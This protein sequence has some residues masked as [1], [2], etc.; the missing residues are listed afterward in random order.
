MVT[1][2]APAP[3]TSAPATPIYQPHGISD[4]QRLFHERFPAL[5]TAHEEEYSANFGRFR[6]PPISWAATA[7]DACGGGDGRQPATGR[8][9]LASGWSGR[10]LARDQ[11][12]SGWPDG[13][14]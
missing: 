4:L 11:G 9:A 8:R 14:I 12:P 1:S 3:G 2:L 6:L 13:V 5:A 7:F 10:G